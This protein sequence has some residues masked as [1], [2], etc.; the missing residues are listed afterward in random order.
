MS[1][2]RVAIALVHYPCVDR[3]G[4]VY[5]TS[6]TNL[7]VHDV[8]RSSRTYDVDAFY[9]VHAI[10]AQR[11]LASAI[12]GF[13]EREGAGRNKNPDRTE[14]FKRVRVV[15][16]IEDAIAAETEAAGA[17]WVVSTSARPA[18]GLV[19]WDAARER[20][21]KEASTL[22]LFGTGHGLAPSA[23]E[24]AVDRLPPVMAASDY[25][26]LS[27]RSAIAIILDRLLGD[28]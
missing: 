19:G 21:P 27:V 28:R 15:A 24:L 13:W 5:A 6:I 20:M 3:A 16:S 4:E 7:D 22:V 12:A 2:P 26:H 10:D 18:D 14:A 25:N 11:D 8:A 1:R 17:P 23:L 9:V